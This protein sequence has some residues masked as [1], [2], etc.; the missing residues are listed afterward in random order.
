M[1]DLCASPVPVGLT[2]PF[3]V[4]PL[5]AFV[6]PMPIE[7]SSPSSSSQSINEE[8]KKTVV[9]QNQ[10]ELKCSPRNKAIHT[11]NL[12]QN[13][14]FP[15]NFSIRVESAINWICCASVN[16]IDS[17]LILRV[18]TSAAHPQNPLR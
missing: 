16:S 3:H 17:N 1:I 8:L 11:D 7:A 2:V 15:E 14:P 9:I 13:L 5:I 12:P 18:F 4:E 10:S 6:S